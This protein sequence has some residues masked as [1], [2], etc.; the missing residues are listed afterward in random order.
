MSLTSRQEH[1]QKA[2][3]ELHDALVSG[4]LS[5]RRLAVVKAPPGSG[6]TF[7]LLRIIGSLVSDGW[8]V[9]IATQTN[10]Q[11]DDLIRQAVSHDV[12]RHHSISRLAA[13]GSNA[14]ES[15]PKEA[16]WLQKPSDVPQVPGL[17]VATAAKWATA[18]DTQGF[19][20]FAVDEAWQ[21]KWAD[22]M[23]CSAVS[24]KYLLIG[25]PGQIPPVTSVDVARWGTSSRPPHKA[26]PDVVLE[27]FLSEAMVGSLPSVRRLP[28]ASVRYVKPFYDFPFEAFS[29]PS[30]RRLVR[31]RVLKDEPNQLTA[32]YL[33]VLEKLFDFEPVLV[34]IPTP[35]DG[36]P[37]ATDDGLAQCIRDVISNLLE[38]DLHFAL[39]SQSPLRPL[40]QQ[41]I[42]VTSSHRAM[43][44]LIRKTLGAELTS[45][46]IDTP[47][48]WQGLE[49][50]L[51]L[52]VHPLS[53]AQE[54]SDFD[55]GTGRLC[56]MASRH[57]LG[58][59][60]FTRDHVRE[61]LANTVTNAAQ[62]PGQP[63]EAGRGKQAHVALLNM[64]A[65]RDRVI[66]LT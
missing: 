18:R 31:Q 48:R 58:L 26:V 14:P 23:R 27:Q 66:S 45:V 49:K 11:A 56:V 62:A 19:D 39:D 7:M 25:D 55:L 33:K 60:L 4:F 47:E 37:L 5:A 42:G 53:G 52:A 16:N 15:F 22:M 38:S 41:D 51:M 50:P 2:G 46:R 32:P 64:L 40:T 28:M 1:L 61:T 63:D 8:R 21:M 44:G 10:T 3:D 65:D 13:S 35:I 29:E 34:T 54:P 9:A 20:L 36:P 24:D 43:N 30:D 57:Q 59:I 12:L 6:K 17:T